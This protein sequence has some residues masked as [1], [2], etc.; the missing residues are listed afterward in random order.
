MSNKFSNIKERILYLLETKKIIKDKFF[1]EI[2]MTYGNFTG[3]AKK[4]PLNSNAISNILL[5]FPDLNAEWLLT[6]QGD[7]FKTNSTKK[8]KHHS[9]KELVTIDTTNKYT[10]ISDDNQEKNELK[11]NIVE[12]STPE[13]NTPEKSITDELIRQLQAKD[14]Q[15]EKMQDQIEKMQDQINELLK[16]MDSHLATDQY[17]AAK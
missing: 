13:Y 4:T 14:N 5:K 9:D 11:S 6:G 10:N 12:E 7:M 15:I 8:A 17:R 3:E 2:G 16:K 1:S